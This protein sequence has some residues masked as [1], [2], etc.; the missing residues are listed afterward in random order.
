MYDNHS[1]ALT[2]REIEILELLAQG[3]T[4]ANIAEQLHLS[5][6][7]I[8]SHKKNIYSKLDINNGIQ[9]GMW[10]EKHLIV[11]QLKIA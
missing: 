10:I 8:R 1:P 6:E 4:L 7:T 2:D 3:H 5:L 11:N 9:L